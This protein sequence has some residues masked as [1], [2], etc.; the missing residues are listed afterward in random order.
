MQP[1]FTEVRRVQVASN[2]AILGRSIFIIE[3]LI[4]AIDGRLGASI[5]IDQALDFGL[6]R[7][8][9]VGD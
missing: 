3:R 7:R 6:T 9:L 8:I 1:F 5:S 2:L 4:H